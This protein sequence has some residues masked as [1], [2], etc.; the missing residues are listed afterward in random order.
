MAKK[1]NE[2]LIRQMELLLSHDDW[3]IT[4]LANGAALLMD[5]V[6]EI[7]WAGFYLMRE[8]ML[9]LGPF[10]GKPACTRIPLGKGVCGVAAAENRTLRVADVGTFPGYIACDTASQSELVVPLHDR[11]GAILGVMDIDSDSPARFSEDDQRILELVAGVIE[12]AIG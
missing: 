7:N 12:R 11:N 9:A 5:T 1:I 8:N 10:Q 3:R 2:I 6:E 4:N